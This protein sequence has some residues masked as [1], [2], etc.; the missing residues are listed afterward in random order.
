[1]LAPTTKQD[2]GSSLDARFST[3]FIFSNNIY[4]TQIS[5]QT[6]I[7]VLSKCSDLWQIYLLW[8]RHTSLDVDL[9]KWETTIYL[10]IWKK[11]IDLRIGRRFENLKKGH[12]S[13][14][15]M[16]WTSIWVLHAYS[17]YTYMYVSIFYSSTRK[18]ICK[19]I[20]RFFISYFVMI[21]PKT[22]DSTN[23]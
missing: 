17:I 9:R 5:V 4:E 14:V 11:D 10:R 21:K 6:Q 15:Q 18:A 2:T 1:M 13:E 12:R 22:H 19:I 20:F 7:G 23:C 16:Y 3:S 8:S